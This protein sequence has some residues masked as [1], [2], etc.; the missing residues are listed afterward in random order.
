MS[1]EA[2]VSSRTYELQRAEIKG[3]SF[4]LHAPAVERSFTFNIREIFVGLAVEDLE[5]L[6]MYSGL[7]I[8]KDKGEDKR[9]LKEDVYGR[10]LTLT[11]K[12]QSIGSNKQISIMSLIDEETFKETLKEADDEL[13][14]YEVAVH[15]SGHGWAAVLMGG[16]VESETIVPGPGYRGLTQSV[17]KQT[18][19]VHEFAL[20]RAVVCL[21]GGAAVEMMGYEA[22][23][24]GSD[25]A[26]AQAM[27]RLAMTDPHC[28]YTSAEQAFSAIRD[29]TRRTIG[30]IGP[31][32]LHASAITLLEKKTIT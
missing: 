31:A 15:E 27:C 32:R 24:T 22:R 4:S 8:S 6:E 23:G 12:Y 19:S 11:E 29:F 21:A 30:N 10:H 26:A 25:N 17:S 3:A 2:P 7:V 20:R 5:N 18:A 1:V 14:D 13:D 9:K 28:P 16:K